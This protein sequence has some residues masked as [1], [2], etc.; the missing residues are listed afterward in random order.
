VI[1]LLV[2]L[3]FILFIAQNFSSIKEKLKERNKLMKP[4][5]DK[6]NKINK[7][8]LSAPQVSTLSSEYADVNIAKAA[9]AIHELNVRYDAGVVNETEFNSELAK[10]L[11]SINIS[12]VKKSA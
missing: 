8:S 3:F 4:V 5:K 10:I 12:G 11:F 9:K 1:T 2:I 6:F 7:E